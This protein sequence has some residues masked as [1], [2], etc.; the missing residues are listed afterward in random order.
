MIWHFVGMEPPEL[1]VLYLCEGTLSSG[2]GYG[3]G[4]GYKG[5]GWGYGSSL[6]RGDG[7]MFGYGS[8]T[9]DSISTGDGRGGGFK[10]KGQQ[11]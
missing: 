2:D 8:L 4:D 7:A 10:F 9:K 1:K 11:K 6:R 5:D 3:E